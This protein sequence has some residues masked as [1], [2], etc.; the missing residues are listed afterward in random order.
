MLEKLQ[1]YPHFH[2]LSCI[3]ER[4]PKKPVQPSSHIAPKF[5]RALIRELQPLHLGAPLQP[6]IRV[7]EQPLPLPALARTPLPP[8]MPPPCRHHPIFSF[9]EVDLG[10]ERRANRSA[11]AE[12]LPRVGTWDGRSDAAGQQWSSPDT[13]RIGGE[14]WPLRGCCAARL[15]FA[16]QGKGGREVS[17]RGRKG[18]PAV[19]RSGTTRLLA[20]YK[21]YRI[22]GGACSIPYV[23]CNVF[24]YE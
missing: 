19:V 15:C 12:L 23:Y 9:D 16:S 22:I 20:C 18:E 17:E 1:P 13:G 8:G 5:R 10:C 6:L 7:D 21:Y 11:R 24:G 14:F 4:K 3:Y 2:L